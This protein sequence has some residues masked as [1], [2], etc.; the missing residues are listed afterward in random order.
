MLLMLSEMLNDLIVDLPIEL[1]RSLQSN[2]CSLLRYRKQSLLVG[3][4]CNDMIC[5]MKGVKR[6]VMCR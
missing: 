5:Y 1:E 4:V 6:L 2:L 3:N